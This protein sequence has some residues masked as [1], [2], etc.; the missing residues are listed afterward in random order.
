MQVFEEDGV[1]TTGD[2]QTEVS[3]FGTQSVTADLSVKSAGAA[4]K[5]QLRTTTRS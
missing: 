2:E 4:L 3:P 5:V 1:I